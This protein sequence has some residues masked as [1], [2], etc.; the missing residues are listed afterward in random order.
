MKLKKINNNIYLVIPIFYLLLFIVDYS[1]IMN[2]WG[3]SYIRRLIN[4]YRRRDPLSYKKK[5]D[6]YCKKYEKMIDNYDIQKLQKIK[7]HDKNDVPW[8][9]RTNTTTIYYKDLREEEKNNLDAIKNKIREKFEKEIGKKLYNIK[10]NAT[11][12]YIYH[13]KESKHLWHVDPQN[14]KSIYNCIICIDRKGDISPLQWKDT[15]N[16]VHSEHLNKGDAAL[17]NG[18]TTIHQVPPNKDPNSKRTVLSVAFT[19]EKKLIL[20]NKKTEFDG[21]NM[22]TY[23]EGGSKKLN[24]LKLILGFFILIFILSKIS[25]VNLLSYRF[26]F[27]YIFFIFI[28]VKYLP[29]YYNTKLGTGRSSSILYNIGLLFIISIAS[30]NIKG[31]I[32]FL[33]YYLLSDQFFPSYWVSYD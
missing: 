3:E 24:I 6:P 10:N 21:Q 19:S 17:F 9:S 25:N 29:L 13:G 4:M 8:F 28:L 5:L 33:S 31:G 2:L 16:N 14:V 15:S 20:K 30:L 27:T 23:I 12:I 22:C 7:L 26:L 1:G 18:G 11:N 32:L